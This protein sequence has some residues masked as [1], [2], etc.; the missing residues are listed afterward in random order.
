M[1]GPIDHAPAGAEA[2][3]PTRDLFK[4]MWEVEQTWM[5]DIRALCDE[6]QQR[7]TRVIR[8]YSLDELDALAA[9]ASSSTIST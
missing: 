6:A 7:G 2:M 3:P 1:K 9:N 5:P 8:I 4:T